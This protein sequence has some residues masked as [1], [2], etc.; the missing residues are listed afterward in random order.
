MAFGNGP[1]IV[2]NGLVL[3]LDASDRNSYPGSG[4]TWRDMSGNGNNG[5]LT[6]GPT[7]NSA[8]GGNFNFDGTDDYLVTNNFI[9][10]SSTSN[11]TI[12]TWISSK[13]TSGGT[14]YLAFLGGNG[15]TSNNFFF[16]EW[17]DRI[18]SRNSVTGN[19]AFQS[20]FTPALPLNNTIFL[21]TLIN[22][23]GNLEL[24]SNITKT[25]V[26]TAL[27]GNLSF[28][29][30]MRQRTG[31]SPG[32]NMYNFNLYNK[33]LSEQEIQQNYNAQK[34]RFGL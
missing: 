13:S 23:S 26:N 22:R 11:W 1:R 20:G 28:N 17:H 32:G 14:A 25:T 19:F 2:S 24:Y 31:V 5:T 9:T 33:A 34:P 15:D 3:A 8:N 18:F 6:N 30:I 12:Q 4:T 27:S 10:L 21:L 29:N 16:F 7:F